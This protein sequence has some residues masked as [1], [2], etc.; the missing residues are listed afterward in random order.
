MSLN[1]SV[2]P[3]R[4]AQPHGAYFNAVLSPNI[5]VTRKYGG[6]HR[7]TKNSAITRLE[8][9]EVP[10]MNAAE[11]NMIRRFNEN[12]AFTGN[13]EVFDCRAG[14]PLVS[15]FSESGYSPHGRGFVFSSVNGYTSTTGASDPN[16]ALYKSDCQFVGLCQSDFTSANAAL[17]EQGLAV[18]CSGIKTIL[19]DS[20]DTIHMG[21]K[22]ML[23]IPEKMGSSRRGV[24]LEKVRFSLKR[25]PADF[26]ESTVIPRM[27]RT[28]AETRGLGQ[29]ITAKYFSADSQAMDI[30]SF[31]EALKEVAPIMIASFRKSARLV[32]ATAV[33]SGRPDHQ[34]DVKLTAPSFI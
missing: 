3:R 33:S 16:E 7:S 26:I 6:R 1:P 14:E 8:K 19:N 31:Q 25:V 5:T 29:K 21:D 11:Q 4:L 27:M 15:S 22:L 9:K 2:I 23:H 17:Q 34:I 24:P 20:A 32:V 12:L 30:V 18:Q 28:L 10:G 13:D